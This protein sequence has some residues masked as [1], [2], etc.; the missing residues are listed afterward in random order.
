MAGEDKYANRE[1]YIFGNPKPDGAHIG[2]ELLA[3][4]GNAWEWSG[5]QWFATK[6][7]GK[8][9]VDPQLQ[10]SAFGELLTVEPTSLV[11]LIFTSSINSRI[12]KT[13][14]NNGGTVSQENRMAKL[15]SGTNANSRAQLFSRVPVKYNPGQGGSIKYTVIFESSSADS[16]QFIGVGDISDGYGVGFQNTVFGVFRRQGG[17]PEIQTLDITNGA[18]TATGNITITLD[19]D[20]K[21]VAVTS[22]DDAR[23]VAVKIADTDFSDVGLGW[24]VDVDSTS[25]TDTVIFRSYDAA[26]KSGTFAFADTDTTGVAASFSQTVVGVATTPNF[27][28]QT[29]W[30]EDK[31]DGT[32]ILPVV[33]FTKGGV[34]TVKYQWL[35]FGPIFWSL[36]NA[37]T[38]DFIVFHKEQYSNLNTIPSINE[39]S[40]PLCAEVKNNSSTTDLIM[41]IGSMGGF[42][43]GKAELA[44]FHN[45]DAVADKGISTAEAP[46]ISFKNKLIFNS[47]LNRISVLPGFIDI[48]TDA[49]KPVIFRL[50]TNGDL[51]GPVSFVDVNTATSVLSVDKGATGIGNGNVIETVVMGKVDSK[52]IDLHILNGK[53]LPGDIISITAQLAAGGSSSS[54]S[55]SMTLAENV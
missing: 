4:N 5:T 22:G 51:T 29:N 14:T 49:N 45:S 53:V 3:T 43:D 15:S 21:V 44:G 23:E 47:R 18:S 11:Q 28:A 7:A 12:V 48:Q 9:I 41:R 6:I 32:K 37:D 50:R 40:L 30:S 26:V 17:S 54:A 16:E 27:T 13:R 35:G 52:H 34:W 42:A 10:K 2:Q 8:V 31:A 20:T 38:D 55:G 33:D 39:P 25:G 1:N 46:L 36:K 24:D 19:D